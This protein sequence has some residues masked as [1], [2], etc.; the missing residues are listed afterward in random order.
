MNWI[1]HLRSRMPR[2][3]SAAISEVT[4]RLASALPLWGRWNRLDNSD[5]KSALATRSIRVAIDS[6]VT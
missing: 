2:F 3:R 1:S 6:A 5:I 4:A